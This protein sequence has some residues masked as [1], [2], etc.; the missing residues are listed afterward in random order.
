M[1]ALLNETTIPDRNSSGIRGGSYRRGK[2]MTGS[3]DAG[4]FRGAGPFRTEKADR[5]QASYGSHPGTSGCDEMRGSARNVTRRPFASGIREDHIKGPVENDRRG[6][7]IPPQGAIRN[8]RREIAFRSPLRK[9]RRNGGAEASGCPVYR[10]RRG[11][12]EATAG[13]PN[14]RARDAEEGGNFQQ[15]P[16]GAIG[17]RAGRPEKNGRAA[18]QPFLRMILTVDLRRA[19]ERRDNGGRAMTDSER[20]SQ[21]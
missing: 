21:G 16:A 8:F 12:A 19:E 17:N 10:F 20:E 1:N 9:N 14:A 11:S 3:A 6:K 15:A 4:I 7:M 5:T 13:I 18:V 2:Y